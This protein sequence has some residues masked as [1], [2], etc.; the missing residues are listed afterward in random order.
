MIGAMELSELFYQM[1]QLGNAGEQEQIEKRTPEVL[2]LYR[3]YKD[4][5][6]EYG[7]APQEGQKQVSSE[8]IRQT[9][10]ALHDAVDAFA[11]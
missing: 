4:I 11:C 10:M 8:K 3:S 9:L 1:E 2:N 6:A 5:L 7:R